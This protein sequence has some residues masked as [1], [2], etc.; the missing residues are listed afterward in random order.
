MMCLE[1]ANEA[2]L[3]RLLR[4][5]CVKQ[6]ICNTVEHHCCWDHTQKVN[7]VLQERKQTLAW[8]ADVLFGQGKEA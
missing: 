5:Q 4:E 7:N 1:L 6:Q 3:R 2:P 8:H